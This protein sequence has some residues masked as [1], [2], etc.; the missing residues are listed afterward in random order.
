MRSL[1]ALLLS[2][3]FLAA[4]LAHGT[5]VAQSSDGEEE[6]INQRPT[7]NG[8]TLN[9]QKTPPPQVRVPPSAKIAP[10]AP[11]KNGP[12]VA[13]EKPSVKALPNKTGEGEPVVKKTPSTIL[14][15]D[16]S[17]KGGPAVIAPPPPRGKPQ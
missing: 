13:K 10:V 9:G 17:P 12:A 16:S 5:A 3:A 2:V 4:C 15:G 7:E 6:D 1:R 8:R 11:A 14:P